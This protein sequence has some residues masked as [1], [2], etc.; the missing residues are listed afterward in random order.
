MPIVK[1]KKIPK[2]EENSEAV[3]RLKEGTPYFGPFIRGSG[4]TTYTCE[5]CGTVL[6]EN[7]YHGKIRN[8]VFLCPKCGSYN[9]IP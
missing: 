3:F 7:V 2:P 1:A 9:K 6:V 4:S 5:L 8:L